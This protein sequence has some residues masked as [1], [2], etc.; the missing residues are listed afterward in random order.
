MKIDRYMIKEARARVRKDRG[1]S[2][3]FDLYRDSIEKCLV[4]NNYC[5][6]GESRDYIKY[7][8]KEGKVSRT[9]ERRCTKLGGVGLAILALGAGTLTLAGPDDPVVGMYGAAGMAIGF[10]GM[11]LSLGVGVVSSLMVPLRRNI[12]DIPKESELFLI[13]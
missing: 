9:V 1:G 2:R 6:A 12:K 10:T 3:E 5:N 4:W 8:L 7:Y 13:D 11:S